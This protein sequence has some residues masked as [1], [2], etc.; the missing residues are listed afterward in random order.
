[1]T[2][3]SFLSLLVLV[4]N[5]NK[6]VV[7]QVRNL[8]ADAHYRVSL[9]HFKSNTVIECRNIINKENCERREHNCFFIRRDIGTSNSWTLEK[10][11]FH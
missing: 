9:S 5:Q 10:V 2:F 3:E 8:C 4:D 1:M 11:Q 7:E 6:N